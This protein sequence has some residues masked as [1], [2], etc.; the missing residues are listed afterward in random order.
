MDRTE[1]NRS[2][3]ILHETLHILKKGHYTYDGRKVF[4]KLSRNRQQAASFY[5]VRTVLS[6]REKQRGDGPISLGRCRYEV[7]NQDAFEAARRMAGNY[8]Y[9]LDKEKRPVLVLN[10][11]N[12]VTP[13]GG[14]RH[15]AAAQEEDL[16][17][18]SSLLLSLESKNAH[19]YYEA[20]RQL[21]HYLATDAMLLSPEVE[22]LRD[23]N[24]D[25]LPETVVVSV[26]TCAAPAIRFA[27]EK[28][29][30][31]Q[32]QK[33]LYGRIMGMLQVA[34]H[35]R[36]RYLILGAWGCG[37]FGND[38]DMV[39]DMF[40]KALKDFRFGKLREKDVFEHIVFAVLDHSREKR[41]YRAFQRNFES[42]YR[43]IDQADNLRAMK[44]IQKAERRLDRIR[45]SLFGGAAGDALGYPVEFMTWEMIRHRYGDG[46][47]QAYV[48]DAERQQALISDDTQMTL[49]TA[50]GLL[51]G[52]T[53]GNLRGI[54]ARP[55]S[56]VHMAYLD[57]LATQM[58]VDSPHP[59]SWILTRKELHAARAPGN[60][61]LSALSSGRMGTIKQPINQS[62]G[63]GGVMRIA[64]V[65]L[66]CPDWK[67]KELE[68]LDREGAEI[69]AITHG[70]PL[71]FIPA[72]FL[73]HVIHQAAFC[74]K[75]NTSL[76]HIIKEALSFTEVLFGTYADFAYFKECIHRAAGYAKS[77]RPDLVCIQNLGGGWVAEEAVAIAVYCALKYQDNFTKALT[78][79]V[80]H[81]GDSD[82]TGALTG[83]ILGAWLGY[84]SIEE[85][86]K[87]NLELSDT[88][89]EVAD[90]LCHGCQMSEYSSYTDMDWKRKY[91]FGGSFTH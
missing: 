27:K 74:S 64:P 43:D 73:T 83:N 63:C 54:A 23:S 90:D 15:G 75:E 30:K 86:W 4:L 19:V 11:A 82:S 3:E 89:L 5:G 45:G 7:V 33:L 37:A 26:L 47:I 55:S 61:C 51:Y 85:K 12:P 79:S 10:F 77:G 38:P 18:K 67:E 68:M 78:A 80:N 2:T 76:P 39:S 62:K 48:L 28:I 46:G 20:H 59:I 8:L 1:H 36:Y 56:Y 88:I 32:L 91:V 41:N 53:R 40:Y 31:E 13:G 42:F 50:C 87:H 16:C 84:D 69:A 25:L 24:N 65:G 21:N 60:T 49:F 81:S 17:R 6:L 22:I 44:R 70:H 9:R 34:A 72:A 14:V 58:P 57:W 66:S 71:G 29:E 52:Q 35:E